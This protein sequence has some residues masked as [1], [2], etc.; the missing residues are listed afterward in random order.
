MLCHGEYISR[1]PAIIYDAFY[2]AFIFL[3]LRLPIV[4]VTQYSRRAWD[5][6]GAENGVVLRARTRAKNGVYYMLTLMLANTR[7]PHE[8][9]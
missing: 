1:L 5:I 9:Y 8:C 3:R 7:K 4:P 2:V 6:C